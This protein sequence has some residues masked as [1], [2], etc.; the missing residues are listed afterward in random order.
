[1]VARSCLWRAQRKICWWN[2]PRM[3]A[4]HTNRPDASWRHVQH[5]RKASGFTARLLLRMRRNR[6]Y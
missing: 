5:V 1:M 3:S 2:P 4:T 6:G